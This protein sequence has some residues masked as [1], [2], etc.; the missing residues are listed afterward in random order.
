MTLRELPDRTFAVVASHNQQGRIGF[1]YNGNFIL[2]GLGTRPDECTGV[3]DCF[4]AGSN[5]S[6]IP[7]NMNRKEI[8]IRLNK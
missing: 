6:L 8:R 7:I 2:L 3:G 4:S 1:K 5:V